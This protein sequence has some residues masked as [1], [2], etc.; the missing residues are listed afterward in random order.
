VPATITPT[1]FADGGLGS[2]SLR[3]AVLQFNADAGSDD[4]IIQL[5]AGTYTLTIKNAGGVHETAGLTGDL[6]LTSTS[7]H[8]IIQGAGPS[9]IIDASQLEDRVFQ[10]VNPATQVVFQDLVIQGGLAQ[11]NGGD[12]VHQGSTDALGGGILNNGGDL[13]LN[14]VV[15]QNNSAQGGDALGKTL[16]GYSARGGGIYSTGGALTLTG[17]TIANNQAM[18]GRGGDSSA[19]HYQAGDGGSASGAGLYASG[20]SLDIS[21][22]RI[23]SDH[24]TGGRG[25]DGGSYSCGYSCIVRLGGSGGVAQGGGLYVNGGSLTLASS[26]IASNQGTG[27]PAG[28]NGTLGGGTGGGLYFASNGNTVTASVS[29]CTAKC[30]IPTRSVS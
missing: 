14:N 5:L 16:P 23:A 29:G 7:H 22:S 12:G 11:E 15:L 27:G 19:A 28:F 21:D 20:G 4:D 10:I 6:N 1:T 26:T 25:G 2:G 3:D 30:T 8:W 9:T 17:A 24:S 13:T 18:G